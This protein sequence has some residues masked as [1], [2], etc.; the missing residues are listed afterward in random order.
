MVWQK[1]TVRS[2]LFVMP[3][4]SRAELPKGWRTQLAPDRRRELRAR[5]KVAR[6]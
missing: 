6:Y 3:R 5:P 1:A 4:E 2:F